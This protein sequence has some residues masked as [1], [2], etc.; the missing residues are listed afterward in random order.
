MYPRVVTPLE[1]ARFQ[2]RTGL[3]YQDVNP[4]V[5][6][7]FGYPLSPVGNTAAP[8][9]TGIPFPTYAQG[10]ANAYDRFNA[11]QILDTAAPAA[12][13]RGS[14]LL[15]AVGLAGMLD[16]P[17]RTWGPVTTRA[18]TTGL[19]RVMATTKALTAGAPALRS[20]QALPR[21][22]APGIGAVGAGLMHGAEWM[23]PRQ[24]LAVEQRMRDQQVRNSFTGNTTAARLGRVL[25]NLGDQM[26]RA[27]DA[28]GTVGGAVT[29]NPWLFLLSNGSTSAMARQYQDARNSKGNVEEQRVRNSI[30]NAMPWYEKFGGGSVS[31]QLE[32]AAYASYVSRGK[33]DPAAYRAW[34][35][36]QQARG[37]SRRDIMK[38]R[39]ALTKRNPLYF[40][41]GVSD[42]DRTR[43]V[44]ELYRQA[45]KQESK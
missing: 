29:G 31:E 9:Y 19:P 40:E 42:A 45:M 22:V 44:S 1:Q 43:S 39:E 26:D 34:Y 12:T 2:R 16:L 8:A 6:R 32:P 33:F 10:F 24:Q 20:F 37:L 27:A 18:T 41:S 3:N 14:D 13:Q 35:A 21:G 36:A 38:E 30:W 25:Y 11:S 17:L 23:K 28:V 5:Q 7:T 4:Y 15:N